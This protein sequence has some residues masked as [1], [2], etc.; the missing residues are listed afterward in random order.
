MPKWEYRVLR[1]DSEFETEKGV[2]SESYKERDQRIEAAF[3]PL[4][5]DGW[6]LVGFLPLAGLAAHRNSW[7]YHAVF[8]RLA[9]DQD[10]G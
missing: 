6:E 5:T 1:I 7:M 3:A 10:R 4:G 9:K 2:H 8:K